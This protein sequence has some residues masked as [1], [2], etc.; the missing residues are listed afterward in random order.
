MATAYIDW[1]DDNCDWGTT[2]I[3]TQEYSCSISADGLHAWA[4][5]RAECLGCA[6]QE[7]YCME[8]GYPGCKCGRMA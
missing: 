1:S 5:A 8:C 6:E 4:Y 2:D 7:S 3:N